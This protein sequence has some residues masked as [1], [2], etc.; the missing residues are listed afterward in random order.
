MET[1]QPPQGEEVTPSYQW[2][3]TN[4]RGIPHTTGIHRIVVDQ[5]KG[6]KVRKKGSTFC[7]LKNV[8]LEGS[9]KV[10]PFFKRGINGHYPNDCLLVQNVHATFWRRSKKKR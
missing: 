1:G 6:K 8:R 2:H 9:P 5:K 7:I 4:E 10:A 3:Q